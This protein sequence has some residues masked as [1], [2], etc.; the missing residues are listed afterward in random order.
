MRKL[1]R[2]QQFV[3]ERQHKAP[4]I[5]AAMCCVCENKRLTAPH[6]V[7]PLPSGERNHSKRRGARP[8]GQQQLMGAVHWPTCAQNTQRARAYL[9]VL[10]ALP[11]GC[12]IPAPRVSKFYRAQQ[13]LNAKAHPVLIFVSFHWLF[14]GVVRTVAMP[15]R[16]SVSA[17]SIKAIRRIN[18][19][20][21]I[22]CFWLQWLTSL[23]QTIRQWKKKTNKYNYKFHVT[24]LWR[25]C[26]ASLTSVCDR[27]SCGI[28]YP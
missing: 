3:K 13:Q 26:V 10:V 8:P 22:I 17:T 23:G 9:S 19:F 27:L 11:V 12:W 15:T 7:L 24:L 21:F 1:H 20:F 5:A 2:D 18:L 14:S 4:A 28:G 6:M 16:A 25:I